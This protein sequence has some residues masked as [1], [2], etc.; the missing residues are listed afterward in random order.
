MCPRK[1]WSLDIFVNFSVICILNYINFKDV[2]VYICFHI[3]LN[4]GVVMSKIC[5][6][7]IIQRGTQIFCLCAVISDID[8]T[9]VFLFIKKKSLI[10]CIYYWN[11]GMSIPIHMSILSWNFV[12]LCLQTMEILQPKEGHKN[13]ACVLLLPLLFYHLSLYIL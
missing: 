10:F 5:G 6:G 11:F 2:I 4:F 7:I 13:L 8:F 12:W 9:E 3:L 1:L